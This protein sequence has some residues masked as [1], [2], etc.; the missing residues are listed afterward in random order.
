MKSPRDP[1]NPHASVSFIMWLIR[2]QDRTVLFD[3]GFYRPELLSQYKIVDFISPVEAVRLAGV[4]PDQITDIIVSHAHL[5]HI[6]GLDL[7][8]KATIWMQ[9]AEYAYYTGPA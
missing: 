1:E 6:G 3:A 5:D 9:Q 8:P 2:G 4:E 7:F